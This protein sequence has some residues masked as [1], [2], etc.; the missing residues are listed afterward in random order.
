MTMIQTLTNLLPV[1]AGRVEDEMLRYVY[2]FGLP[3]TVGAVAA[4][5][6]GAVVIATAR[7]RRAAGRRAVSAAPASA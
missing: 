3:V 5:V 6:T 4:L 7:A 1:L 2:A